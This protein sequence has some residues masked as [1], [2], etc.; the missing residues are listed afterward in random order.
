MSEIIV[1]KYGGR[2]LTC[3]GQQFVLLAAPT[4]AEKGVAVVLPNLLNFD[5]SVVVL[6]LKMENFR[7]T[8]K[9]RQRHGQQIYLFAPFAENRITH[10]WNMLDTVARD[11]VFRVGDVLAIGQVFYPSDCDPREKFWNDN[12][13]NLFLAFVLY[14]MESPELPCTLGEVFRQSSGKGLPLK[15]HIQ[16]CLA[17]RSRTDAPLSTECLDAFGRFLASPENTLGNIIST[18]NAPLLV[19]ANPI[20][21]AATSRSDFDIADLRKARISL[22]IGI[23][24]QRLSDAAL[25]VNMLFSRIIETNTKELPETNPDLKHQC[26]LIMDEFPALGKVNIIAKANSFIRGYNLRLLTIVQSIAQLE[27]V[28]GAADARTLITNHAVQIIYPPSEQKDANDYS[29]M[30]GYSTETA[31]STGIN[32]PRAFGQPGSASENRSDQR[33]ALMLPQE[34][35]EMAQDQQIVLVKHCKPVRC[36]K[37]RY[38]EDHRFID[39]LKE[40]SPT[41]AALDDNPKSA[42]LRRWGLARFAKVRPTEQQIKHAAFVMEDM[43]SPIPMLD[44]D[45]HR[46]R[47]E[48]RIRPLQAGEPIDLDRLALNL[49]AIAPLGA[50]ATHADIEVVV[51][52]FFAQLDQYAGEGGP[53]APL[54]SAA[55][56]GHLR[57]ENG[58]GAAEANAGGSLPEK[59]KSFLNTVDLSQLDEPKP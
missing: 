13:R 44:L 30:L 57:A 29:E 48:R 5:G 12:A 15:D 22:Y 11:P 47:V 2:N 35:K 26:L 14:L 45:L 37:A 50:N 1:G 8:S 16:A 52:Q 42:L 27:A 49:D 38:Y 55:E 39:R 25:L 56:R 24:P 9:F 23:A 53:G 43:S 59:T 10:C 41:L 4:G 54:K 33:R 40:V 7:L 6:D 21:D 36:T 34:L 46:A 20:V 3:K 28:Y 58:A 31:V 18:F 19:F 32:R 51:D 17:A